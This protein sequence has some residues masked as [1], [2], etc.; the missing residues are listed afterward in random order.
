MHRLD[1]LLPLLLSLLLLGGCA[2]MQKPV[3]LKQ[4]VLAP[5]ARIG[6]AMAPIPKANTDFPGAG[7]LLCIAAAEATHSTLTAYVQTLPT[8]D[9]ASLK[10]ELAA[11]LRKKGVDAVVIA[12]PLKVDELPEN[13]I[14]G[15]NIARRDFS[16]LRKKYGVDRLLLIQVTALGVTRNYSAYV[17]TSPPMGSL[18]GT[19]SIVNL[20]TNTYEWHKIVAVTRASDKTWDEPPK[21]PGMSNAY[22]QALEL[23]KDSFLEPFVR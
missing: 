4:D 16:A 7:C 5:G 21:F 18:R 22:F 2:A 17:P 20:S 10:D 1:R 14:A 8:D 15:D 6:V 13:A 11:A 3:A 19:G 9:L 12:E 23:G